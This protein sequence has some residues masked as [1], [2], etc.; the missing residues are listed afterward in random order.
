MRGV[1]PDAATRR[2]RESP[3]SYGTPLGLAGAVDH[4]PGDQVDE[5]SDGKQDEAARDQC[6]PSSAAGFAELIGDVRRDGRAARHQ[7]LGRDR[8]DVADDESDG[9]RLAQGAPES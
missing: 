8:E 4:E 7:D 6:A 9:D 2:R 1:A 5:E 3:P